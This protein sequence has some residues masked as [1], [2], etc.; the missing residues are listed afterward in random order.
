[1]GGGII[2]M[3]CWGRV[4]RCEV[5]PVQAGDGKEI[6]ANTKY[7]RRQDG[8]Y[9]VV[10][11]DEY[12]AQQLE[13]QKLREDADAGKLPTITLSELRKH[14]DPDSL[15][16]AYGGA[17]YDITEFI[18]EHPGGSEAL[19]SAGGQDLE[20]VWKKYQIHFRKDIMATLEAY[21]IGSLT[22]ED[23]E[24][25]R[26]DS[27]VDNLGTPRLLENGHAIALP[28]HAQKA[29]VRATK[30]IARVFMVSVSASVWWTLRGFLRFV[31]IVSPRLVNFL[32]SMLPC[33]VPGYA[34]AAMLP[35]INPATGTPTRIAVIGGGIGGCSCAYSLAQSGYDVTVYE[36]REVLGGN[37]QTANYLVNG[38]TI[39]QDLSVLYWA[40]EFYRNYTNLVEMLGI[41]PAQVQLPYVICSNRNGHYDFYVPPGGASCL[42]QILKPSMADFFAEDFKKYGRMLNTIKRVNTLFNFNSDRPS[43]YKVNTYAVLPLFNPFNFIGMRTASRLFGVSSQ[44]FETVVRPFHGIN[45][46][47]LCFDGVPA[48]AY[49]TLES[50]APLQ[51]VRQVNTFDAG[52]S[53]EVFKRATAKCNVKLGTRVRQ[54]HF[55][56][57][58]NEWQQ[59]VVDDAGT[60]SSFD[61][62]V[63]ACPATAVANIIR[64][65]S[66]IE[67]SL[68]N[69]I[70]YHDEVHHGDWQDWLECTVHQDKTC[71]PSEHRDVLAERAAF[72]ANVDESGRYGGGRNVEYTVNVGS[73]SPARKAA[74]LAA[75]DA[76]MFM[77]QSPHER[78]DVDAA[79]IRGSFSAPKSHPDLSITNMAITQMLHL[80][81]GRRGAYYCSNWTSPGNGHDL[82]CTSG[83]A[84]A[85]VIGAEY[86]LT[87]PEARRDMRDCRRFMGI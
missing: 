66:W 31:G 16:V 87:D 47:T 48:T 51:S 43:F 3:G 18:K 20:G 17:V 83:L 64:P 68:F 37:A 28:P 79:A 15:W 65:A 56:E 70:G 6:A 85:S 33:S 71:L 30:R 57:C 5:A 40:P 22:E 49:E 39:T 84:V 44:F 27:E 29:K 45:L 9:G 62:V 7:G 10:T 72:V 13:S 63:F 14:T 11:D 78:F 50:I 69:G 1:M 81:Q 25:L 46:T 52:T 73:F 41:S 86:P 21:R 74:G 12:S 42:E 75:S 19:L 58:H 23:A 80:V 34:G 60:V 82:A 76:N 36:S 35:P 2:V 32:A 4:L 24:R 53:Q 8:T 61:R 54:V 26:N 38:K 77:T 55:R 59:D 67:S